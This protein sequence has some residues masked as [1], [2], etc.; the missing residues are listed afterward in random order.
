MELKLKRPLVFIDLETTGINVSADRIVEISALKVNPNGIEQWMTTLV[1]PGIPI[2]PKVTA[3]HGISDSDVAE[4]PSFREIAKTLTSFLEGCDLAGFNAM[5][6]DIP[7]LAEEF[8]RANV[9]FNFRKRKYIDVQ[10][11]FHK[12]EQ[13]TLEAAFRF[14]CKRELENAHSAKADTAATYEVLKAQLDTY[15]DLENDVDKLAEFSSFNNN[16]DF[17]GR[18]ILDENGIETFNFGKHKGRRVDEVFREEPSYYSWMM[19]GDFPL[20]TKKILTEIKLRAFGSK[21]T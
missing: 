2:P 8:L 10:V 9:D 5:K 11:I 20:Y 6:F 14:Y 16:V 17:A 18:I 19:N 7:V 15:T 1:N 4:A 12:K 13:R 21:Q 3:I